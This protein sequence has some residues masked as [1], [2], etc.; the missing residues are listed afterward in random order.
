MPLPVG[1]VPRV[2]IVPRALLPT[3]IALAYY[4]ELRKIVTLARRLVRERL[5]SRLPEM[6]QRAG[7]QLHADAPHRPGSVN[8]IVGQIA[9]AVGRAYPQKRLEKIATRYASAT[10]NHQRDQLFNQ[11][12]PI[13]GIPLKSIVDRKLKPTV[14]QFVAENVALIR[15]VPADYFQDVER[16]VLQG[17]SAGSRADEIEGQLEDR[18]NVAQNRSALIARDQV[19]RFN[20][21]L[22]NLRQQNLGVE[23]YIWRGTPDGRERPEHVEN[24]DQVFSWDDPPG[25]PDDPH[26]GTHPGTAINCRC[27][28]E[29]YFEDVDDDGPTPDVDD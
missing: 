6:V 15:T 1:K 8:W 24:N 29:P 21:S 27:Y 28:G 11:M 5:I 22:N 19:L 9:D 14:K 26:V 20:G 17:M 16:I 25:D 4:A 13:V 10:S 18:A 7:E 12:K 23:K 3:G 2:G